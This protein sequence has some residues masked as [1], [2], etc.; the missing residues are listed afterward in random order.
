MEEL[1]IGLAIT[2]VIFAIVAMFFE[3][4]FYRWQTQQGQS[5]SDNVSTFANEMHDL[6]GELRGLAAGTQETQQKQ[7][8]TMLDALVERQ[9]PQVE[10][11]VE[12]STQF[13]VSE[14]A[15]KIS[16]IESMVEQSPQ[17]EAVH[18]ELGAMRETLGSLQ[19]DMSDAVARGLQSVT[20]ESSAAKAKGPEEVIADLAVNQLLVVD[21]DDAEDQILK[22]YSAPWNYFTKR[23]YL[24]LRGRN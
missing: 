14:L 21:D 10:A 7:V 5:I 4:F 17:S 6:V 13:S 15:E 2:A 12:A 20:P 1:T 3:I 24:E 9:A 18:K 23:G 16:H 11:A 8:Q 22:K 19:A